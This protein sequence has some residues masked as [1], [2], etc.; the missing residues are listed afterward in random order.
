MVNV[1][2]YAMGN[3]VDVSEGSFSIDI[4]F[5]QKEES[6]TWTIINRPNPYMSTAAH[7]GPKTGVG[8]EEMPGPIDKPSSLWN[9]LDKI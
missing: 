3:G 1:G 6:T 4:L 5:K 9:I 2:K 8:S 7:K